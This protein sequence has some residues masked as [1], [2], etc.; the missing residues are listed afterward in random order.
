MP[1]QQRDTS[2]GGHY[3]AFLDQVEFRASFPL[4]V[5]FSVPPC[6]L[7]GNVVPTGP[8]STPAP[9]PSC[10]YTPTLPSQKGHEAQ[11]LPQS[12]THSQIFNSSSAQLQ[13]TLPVRPRPEDTDCFLFLKLEFASLTSALCGKASCAGETCTHICLSGDCSCPFLSHQCNQSTVLI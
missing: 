5:W 6:T 8:S 2:R 12:F 10:L 11:M 13:A 9:P 1:V 7:R 3:T 4:Q